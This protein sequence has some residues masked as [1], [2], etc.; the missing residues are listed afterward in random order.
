MITK[1]KKRDGRIV[2]YDE[3]RISGAIF[4]AARS[5]GGENEELAKEIAKEV[6]KIINCKYNNI[7]P[8]VEDIKELVEKVLVERGHYKTAK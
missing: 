2:P 7:I 5:V 4:K 1:V 3:S 8:N 6:T